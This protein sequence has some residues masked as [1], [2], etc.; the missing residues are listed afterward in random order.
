MGFEKK[1][2]PDVVSEEVHIRVVQKSLWFHTRCT[3][4]PGFKEPGQADEH[5]IDVYLVLVLP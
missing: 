5:K 1:H 2:P 4:T 3:V